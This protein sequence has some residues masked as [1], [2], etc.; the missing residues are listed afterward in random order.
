[1]HTALLLLAAGLPG[2]NPAL[3]EG[4]VDPFDQLQLP[5]R[6]EG[7]WL[8]EREASDGAVYHD[9][10]LTLPMTPAWTAR[11]TLTDEGHGRCRVRLRDVELLGIYQR[12]EDRLVL[13]WRG[14]DGGRPTRFVD[15]GCADVVI[16]RRAR[17]GR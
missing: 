7:L 16:L 8:R 5:G 9:G 14:A 3:I 11:L 4:D 17:A 12:T 1:M 2:D 10:R 13:C 15:E 6:W